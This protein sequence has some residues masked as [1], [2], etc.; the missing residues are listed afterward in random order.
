MQNGERV[1]INNIHRAKENNVES[2]KSPV[3]LIG[4]G[5]LDFCECRGNG[6]LNLKDFLN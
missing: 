6:K 4:G 2:W 3:S 5:G 1:L